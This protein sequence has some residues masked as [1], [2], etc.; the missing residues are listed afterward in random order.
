LLLSLL[1]LAIVAIIAYDSGQEALKKTIGDKLEETAFQAIDKIDRLLFFRREDIKAWVTTEIMQDVI[2]DDPDGR[3]SETLMRLKKEYGVYSGIFCINPQGKIIAS[4]EPESIGQDVSNEPRF[5]E[6][7]KVSKVYMSDL[8]Y[9]RLVGDFAV[10]FSAPIVASYNETEIIGLLSSSLSGKELFEIING[11]PVNEEGQTPSGYALMVNNQGNVISA[12]DFILEGKEKVLSNKNL[13]SMGLESAQRAIQG[14]KGFL[15]ETCSGGKEWLI[16]YASSQGYR[17]FG[18]LGWA[19]LIMQEAR[20]AYAPVIKLRNQFMGI[21]FGVAI[22][23]FL[24]AVLISR[25]ITIPIQ[26]FT[27]IANAIAEGDLSQTIHIRTKDEIGEL[28]KAFNHMTGDLKRSRDELI[29]SLKEKEVLLREIHHRVKNNMQVVSSLLKL[30]SSYI[31]DKQ[32]VE[33]FKESQNRIKSMA[34][35]HEKLYQVKDLARIDFND[36]IR[37]LANGLFR[38][39]RVGNGR[40][41]LKVDAEGVSLGV[42]TAIPCGLIINELVSNSLKYAFTDG[43]EG[44]IEIILRAIDETEMELIVS[45]NG[46]GISEDLDFKNTKS[47]GLQLVATLVEDQLHGRIELNRAAGTEFRIKFKEIKY[48]ERI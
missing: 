22:C 36:Y 5:R 41:S 33:M 32:Y 7:L 42:D 39:Y 6:A 48:K 10:T 35:I 2:A 11:I 28:A 18:G 44:K 12:P 47:L 45:D 13:L 27:T 37:N 17:D 23:V 25:G 38:S 29:T 16:G 34:L 21:S 3:I 40:I 43:R 31:K 1:P 8:K 24:L 19:V 15:I 9:D 46:V 4:S 14:K 20:E 26:K 30:Q